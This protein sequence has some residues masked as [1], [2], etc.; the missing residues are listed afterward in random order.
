MRSLK[1]ALLH[2]FEALGLFRMTA[3]LLARRRLQILCYHGFELCDET[4]FKPLLFIKG[5]TFA[6]R[7]A[8]LRRWGCVV[9]PLDEAIA[10]LRAGTLPPNAVAI[11]IDDGFA[12]TLMVAAPLL[13][14]FDLPA[15]VY[16]TSY[17]MEKN[18]P[19]FRL[20]IQYVFWK[21]RAFDGETALIEQ[22]SAV[23][24]GLDQATTEIPMWTLIR[25]GESLPSE[26]ERQSLLRNVADRARVDIDPLYRDR[27][28]SLMTAQEVGA[29]VR[30]GFDVEL[31]THRH[32][33]PAHDRA[34]A[35]LEIEQN[36]SRLERL[37]GK[38]AYHF[39][40]PSGLFDPAQWPWLEAL[41]VRS[42]TTCLP[43]LNSRTTPIYGLRRF[44]DSED[45]R[46]IEFRAELA[47]FNELLRWTTRRV[48]SRDNVTRSD[49]R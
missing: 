48:P 20:A 23:V 42:A 32:R 26:D 33:F 3:A 34:A 1:C 25:H 4:S 40:Y 24:P 22:L 16:V 43:G 41:A 49:I 2:L 8:L 7:L 27:R 11:T 6:A 10:R 28:L 21:V 44:L 15:T 30:E 47:G 29:I 17:Y 13:K 12:S 38:P 36:R 45:V 37:T 14:R 35:I 31:H 46:P 18:V 9:L 5:T 19:V 39:C